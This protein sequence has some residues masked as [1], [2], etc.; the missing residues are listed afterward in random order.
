MRPYELLDRLGT[1]MD[2]TFNEGRVT[3]AVDA[4]LGKTHAN[5]EPSSGPASA[6]H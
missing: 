1:F 4:A 3:K 6:S 5:E 2:K